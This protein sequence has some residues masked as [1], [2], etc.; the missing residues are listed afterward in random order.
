M[1]YGSWAT[2]EGAG[3]FSMLVPS[4]SVLVHRLGQAFL[5][6]LPA[7]SARDQRF[8]R[9]VHLQDARLGRGIAT[10][11]ILAPISSVLYTSERTAGFQAR[12][13]EPLEPD[14]GADL[15]QPAHQPSHRPPVGLGFGVWGLGFRV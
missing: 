8:R 9:G 4:L 14:S 2:K 10:L 13:M 3:V 7:P 11:G 5:V 6:H 15:G 1:Q 12:S